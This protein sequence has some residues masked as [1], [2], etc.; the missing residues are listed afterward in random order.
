VDRAK[1][2]QFLDLANV[3]RFLIF[4]STNIFFFRDSIDQLSAFVANELKQFEEVVNRLK[5][6]AEHCLSLFLK[7]YEQFRK[8]IMQMASETELNGSRSVND[9]DIESLK[10]KIQSVYRIVEKN[11]SD[12][13]DPMKRLRQTLQD[14]EAANL[15]EVC[16]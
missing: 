2:R 12:K 3:S 13:I 9:F 8:R 11:N 15:V 14:I 5:F 16:C 6:E 4:G 7:R 10:L 1:R